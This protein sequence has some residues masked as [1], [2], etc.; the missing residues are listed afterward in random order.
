M[1]VTDQAL[2]EI[3]VATAPAFLAAMCEMVDWAG[4]R[5]VVIDCSA[6]TFMDS[7][8]CHALRAA[9]DYAIEH[10]HVVVIRGLAENCQRVL[11]ICDPR[12]EL[13]IEPSIVPQTRTV[14]APPGRMLG[15]SAA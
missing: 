10:D 13:T 8:A 5:A 12:C 15:V 11:R 6:I 1:Q 2:T 9:H 4:T 3:D 7:S 14:G